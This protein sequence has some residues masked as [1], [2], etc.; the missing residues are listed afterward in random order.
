MTPEQKAEAKAKREEAK[1][2]EAEKAALNIPGID[3]ATIEY[4]EASSLSAWDENPRSIVADEAIDGI[5][6]DSMAHGWNPA[7]PAVIWSDGRVIQ[8]NRRL[9]FVAPDYQV[10]CVVYEGDEAGATLIALND[11]G[12]GIIEKGEGDITRAA[13]KLMSEMG[14]TAHTLVK[15]L[16]TRSRETLYRLSP[17]AKNAK[18]IAKAQQSSRGKLQG[19]ERIAKLPGKHQEGVYQELNEGTRKA[20][21]YPM[22]VIKKMTSKDI[23]TV[24]EADK[25]HQEYVAS[26]EAAETEESGPP[27]RLTAKLV[28]DR[29]LTFSSEVFQTLAALFEKPEDDSKDRDALAMLAE[30]DATCASRE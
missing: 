3:N 22:D 10:P 6:K 1:D 17:A 12:T 5:L 8:G 18:D 4:R 14:L 26:L 23:K 30:L 29:K 21:Q 25:I 2:K 24:A 9:Q 15:Y 13:V 20:K 16:W 19:L 27:N 28:V 7:Y 11:T